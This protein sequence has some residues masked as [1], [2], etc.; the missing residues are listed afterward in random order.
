MNY[1]ATVA[2]LFLLLDLYAG[3]AEKLF[4][5]RPFKGT[6]FTVGQ[7]HLFCKRSSIAGK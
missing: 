5:G 6:I 4:Y 3:F 1:I 7:S 2:V